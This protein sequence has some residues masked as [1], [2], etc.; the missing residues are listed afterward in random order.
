MFSRLLAA[1]FKLERKKCVFF[2]EELEYLSYKISNKGLE[3]CKKT[4]DAIA[5]APAPSNV[6][7]VRSFCGLANYYGKF[8]HNMA[9]ILSPL[10]KLLKKY[11]TFHWSKDCNESFLQI[12]KEITSNKILC[13]F[14]P[15]KPI[16]LTC[17][18][19]NNGIGAILSHKFP[20]GETRPIAFASRT[21]NKAEF[22]Y[23]IIHKEALAIVYGT[24]KFF[25]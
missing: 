14:D 25:Q 16:I 1:R 7:E 22:N 15:C 21:L 13:H 6:N 10:Y 8:V 18:A 5:N 4:V 3:K 12:K 9:S 23:S 20:N 2:T 17:D 19:S 11:V 24:K